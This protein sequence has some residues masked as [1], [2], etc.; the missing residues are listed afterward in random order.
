MFFFHIVLHSGVDLIR[1]SIYLR[2]SPIRFLCGKSTGL[3]TKYNVRNTI[4]AC[5]V[6]RCFYLKI[7]KSYLSD[8]L[9]R[10]FLSGNRSEH[11]VA[12]YWWMKVPWASSHG[13]YSC[14]EDTWPNLDMTRQTGYTSNKKNIRTTIN[15]PALL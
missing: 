11:T 10:C 13:S 3:S 5:T 9:P 7:V 15:S 14:R 2:R 8:G 1:I 4:Q 12:S 6:I